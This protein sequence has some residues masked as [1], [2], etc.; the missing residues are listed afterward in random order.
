MALSS[1]GRHPG[2][3]QHGDW[4]WWIPVKDELDPQTGRRGLWSHVQYYWLFAV[5]FSILEFQG[6][7]VLR[8]GL[9][10][11]SLEFSWLGYHGASHYLPGERREPSFFPSFFF[12][13]CDKIHHKIDHLN[14]F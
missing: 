5:S 6:P 12:F 3:H 10:C 8:D 4:P 2:F 11:L 7:K 9:V 1:D 14:P 13:Y